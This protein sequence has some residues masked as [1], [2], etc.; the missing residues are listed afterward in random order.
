MTEPSMSSPSCILVTGAAGFLGR[1]V[2]ATL[3]REGHNVRALVHPDEDVAPLQSDEDIELVRADLLKADD[4]SSA[5]AGVDVLI[6]LA[7]QMA[8]PDDQVYASAVDG[9]QR[10]LDAMAQSATRRLVL[11][12]SFSA[13]D[14]SRVTGDVT[15]ATPVLDDARE[16]QLDAYAQAKTAQ[17]HLVR[18]ISA[19]HSW[20]L[21]VLRAPVIW[22]PGRLM[23]WEVGAKLGPFMCV[24]SPG[25]N[26][27]LSYVE[28]CAEAVVAAATQPAAVG[29]TFNVTDGLAVSRWRYAQHV[30]R[31]G[32][33]GGVCVPVPYWAGLLIAQLAWA[34]AAIVPGGR[35]RLPGLLVPQ[36][37][38][39]RFKG[40]PAPNDLLR[41]TLGWSPR[42]SFEQAARNAVPSH[43]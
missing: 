28:H 33:I 34:I 16:A 31:P 39:A 18:Q 24:V 12:S 43:G 11:M 42:L 35:M 27:R 41:N 14:W 40:A 6:H 26:V 20:E 25:A 21:T 29:Q 37:Y 2:V 32:G 38:R 15:E 17:E 22:G 4:L 1:H 19:E 10:L 23:V 30:M 7:A 13:Y 9:S 36:R 8:G 5:L 3:R